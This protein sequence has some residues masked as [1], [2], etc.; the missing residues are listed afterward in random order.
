M[1]PH[2][3]CLATCVVVVF[4]PPLDTPMDVEVVCSRDARH[5]KDKGVDKIH[6]SAVQVGNDILTISWSW[7]SEN[8]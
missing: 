3:K 1:A 2:A 6:H 7:E 4:V 8:G 5:M